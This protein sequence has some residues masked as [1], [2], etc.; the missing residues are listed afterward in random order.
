VLLLDDALSAVDTETEA[1]IL[2]H[3]RQARRM[4]AVVVVSHRLSAVA[5][6]GEIAVLRHGRVMEQG[7]HDELLTRDGWYA[8]QWRYQQLQA[9]LEDD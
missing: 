1:R 2:D 9:S 4:R 7:T 3:L 8:T 5:D 6:A